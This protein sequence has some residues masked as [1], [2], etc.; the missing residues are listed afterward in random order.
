MLQIK[1][2]SRKYE[3]ATFVIPQH[4]KVNRKLYFFSQ[5]CLLCALEDLI[6]EIRKLI[7]VFVML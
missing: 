5:L 1:A 4:H 7:T 3:S 2:S 6:S